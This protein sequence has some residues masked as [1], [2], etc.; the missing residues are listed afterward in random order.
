MNKK[1]KINFK[2]INHE[3]Y[4]WTIDNINIFHNEKNNWKNVY[5]KNKLL[6]IYN[7][8]MTKN[9]K[10][11]WGIKPLNSNAKWYRAINIGKFYVDGYNGAYENNDVHFKL[12]KIKTEDYEEIKKLANNY[13][14]IFQ[15][16][17]PTE[18]NKLITRYYK[19]DINIYGVLE[20][21]GKKLT[22][23]TIQEEEED[24]TTVKFWEGVEFNG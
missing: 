24:P 15:P 16:M 22:D 19:K 3:V 4:Q 10:N 23:Y 11:E 17:E 1:Q 13:D 20:A 9:E 21:M 14:D 5:V 12:I 7:G 6:F 2:K 18:K 8:P